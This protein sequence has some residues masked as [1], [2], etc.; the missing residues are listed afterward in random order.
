MRRAFKQNSFSAR[1]SKA[2]TMHILIYIIAAKF[3]S[4]ERKLSGYGNM[5]SMAAMYSST[6]AASLGPNCEVLYTNVAFR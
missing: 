3:S 2:G 4:V 1:G 5:F 6:D